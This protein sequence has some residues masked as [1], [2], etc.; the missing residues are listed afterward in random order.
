MLLLHG[1]AAALVVA[2]IW[3]GPSSG[4]ATAQ[5]PAVQPHPEVSQADLCALLTEAEAEAIVG[6]P[7]AAPELQR[8]GDCWYPEQAGAGVGGEIILHVFPHR[9]D[10]PEKF[11]AF[12]VKETKAADES[13][14]K[15]MEGTG[16]TITETVVEP[17]PEVQAP[18][19]Y[20]DPTLFVLKDGRVL[21]IAASRAQAAAVAA[22]ALPRFR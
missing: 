5:R 3:R 2:L 20:A 14:K 9:F 6:K 17:V 16:A 12:L 19:Y 22:K 7:L 18:A 8:G 21:G 15:A 4:P 13:L 1:I 10:S 11:H